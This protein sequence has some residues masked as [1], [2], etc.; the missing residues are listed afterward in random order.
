VRPR[1]EIGIDCEDPEALAP[2]WAAALGYDTGDLDRD[3]TYLDLV[4]PEKEMP[5]VYLQRVSEK[6]VSK[7]RLHLDLF[8]SEPREDIAALESIGATPLGAPLT[9]SEGGWW[10]V[11]ADPEGNEFCVCL[12]YEDRETT[13]MDSTTGGSST[14]ASL[15]T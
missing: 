4:P 7:N 15:T 13:P 1:L 8:T 3:G 5:I 12:E 14:R 6:K 10:Q 2:F 11:M 9:G